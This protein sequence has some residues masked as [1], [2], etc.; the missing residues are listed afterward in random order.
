[1]VS[2]GFVIDLEWAD[3]F[4]YILPLVDVC[5]QIKAKIRM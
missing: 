2:N 5:G 1:M 3:L 4:L